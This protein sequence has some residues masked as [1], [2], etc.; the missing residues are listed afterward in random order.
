MYI[1]SVFLEDKWD[2]LILYYNWGNRKLN[3]LPKI[4]QQSFCGVSVQS[5]RLRTY[6]LEHNTCNFGPESKCNNPGLEKTF[7]A[8]HGIRQFVFTI[9][10]P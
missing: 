1:I 10:T 3:N 9:N 6:T 7:S 8:E 2:N 4:I 5:I